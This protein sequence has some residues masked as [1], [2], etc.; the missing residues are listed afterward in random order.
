MGFES[1][2]KSER[3]GD[4]FFDQVGDLERSCDLSKRTRRTGDSLQSRSEPVETGLM[5]VKIVLP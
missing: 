2:E 5:I 1:A 3:I 4:V